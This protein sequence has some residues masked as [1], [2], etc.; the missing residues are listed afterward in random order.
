MSDLLYTVEI[1]RKR[2]E[3]DPILQQFVEKEADW[4]NAGWGPYRSPGAAR[5]AVARVK[6]QGW[7]T[8]EEIRI[9]TWSRT[10]SIPNERN[11]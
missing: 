9:S 5:A 11:K 8:D 1:F 3:W 2:Q 4:E 7:Y 10:G 6:K